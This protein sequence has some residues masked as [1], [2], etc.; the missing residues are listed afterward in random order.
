MRGPFKETFGYSVR[1]KRA[2]QG[3]AGLTVT[4]VAVAGASAPV[5]RELVPDERTTI[6]V[7][8]GVLAR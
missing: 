8:E 2:I 3:A 4:L 6:H 7:G 1:V 5:A